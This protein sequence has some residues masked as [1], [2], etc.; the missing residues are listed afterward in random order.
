MLI[1][2]NILI[3]AAEPQYDYVRKFIS[4]KNSMISIISKNER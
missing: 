1:D 4:N 3:Y 2:S